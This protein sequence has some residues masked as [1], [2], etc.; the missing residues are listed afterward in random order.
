VAILDHVV[1]LELF[2]A[3]RH[4]LRLT[5][6]DDRGPEP[7]LSEEDHPESVLDIVALE[8]HPSAGRIAEDDPAI[9]EDAIHVEADEADPPRDRGIDRGIDR[10]RGRRGGR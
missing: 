6:G 4:T 1:H 9:G 5:P 7:R 10:R 2:G 8:L 3:E